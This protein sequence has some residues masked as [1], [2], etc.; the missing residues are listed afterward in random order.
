MADSA[1]A[2]WDDHRTAEREGRDALLVRALELGLTRAEKEYGSADGEGWLWS[3][4]HSSNV[5]HL[6]RLAPLSALGLP[7]QGGTSTI[8][9]SPGNGTHG[10]SWRMVVELGPSVRAWGTYPGGQSGNPASRHYLDRIPTWQAGHLDSLFF[11]KAAIEVAG[12]RLR[13]TL[14]LTGGR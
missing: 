13:S 2:W 12:A 7:V 4:A 9:P 1:S 5:N 14:M 10:A 11:P 8:G 3:R 6:L